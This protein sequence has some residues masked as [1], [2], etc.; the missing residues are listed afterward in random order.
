MFGIGAFELLFIL[1]LGVVILGPKRIP[2]LAENLG[3][4]LR[5]FNKAKN[6]FLDEINADK[7]G[8][9]QN[10][11]SHDVPLVYQDKDHNN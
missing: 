7:K 2:I 3:K 8:D 6:S 1:F 10:D 9:L 11:V 4:A 5:E